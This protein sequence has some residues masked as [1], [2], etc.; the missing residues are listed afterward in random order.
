MKIVHITENHI[1]GWGYQEN[2]LPLYQKR[3]GHDVAVI[4]D[5]DHL[6]Y[7]QNPALAREI[8][9]RGRE[10]EWDGIR[11]YKIKTYLTTTT[12]ALF[13]R[14]VYKILEK[15]KPDVIFHHNVNISTLTVAARYRRRH[16]RVTLYAD[17]HADWI[18]ESKNR[19]WH[20]FYCKCLIPLQVGR[21]GDKVKYY[22]GVSPLRCRYLEEVYKV[23]KEKIRFL[24]I[25]CDTEQA[26]QVTEERAGLRARFHLPE[27]AFVVVSGGKMDR[28]KGT[29]EL[30]AACE[31]M[32]Q[33]GLD[34]R[35]VLFGK[36]DKELDAA[37]EG[38]DWIRCLDWCNR[39][40]TMSLLKLAD[41]ACWPWLHT[42]LIEDAV[43]AGTP[44]VVKW[45]DNVSHFVQEKPGVFLQRGDCEELV[46]ALKEIA[47]HPALYR[48]RVGIAREK[49]SYRTLV[50]V[51]EDESFCDCHG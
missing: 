51:L 2:L 19:L 17:N 29:L 26:D 8:I 32:R 31:E 16:P 30:K 18:N 3:A 12:D 41:V 33:A 40:T 45:S 11:I 5:N 21:I 36:R 10:Y 34:L 27:D 25:G 35:L 37:V 48:E 38:K 23:P 20:F 50:R 28:S 49:Y 4:S 42:T 14:G 46:S 22:I 9:G 7:I 6:R 44:I 24:P 47:Q 15:E 1:D 39:E 43:A 13:C